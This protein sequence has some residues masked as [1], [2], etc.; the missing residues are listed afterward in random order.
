MEDCTMTIKHLVCTTLLTLSLAMT[1]YGAVN[2]TQT[3]TAASEDQSG[4][5]IELT[6]SKVI[7]D[8]FSFKVPDDWKG[9]CMLIQDGDNLEVYDKTAYDEDGSGLLFTIAVYEDT[10]YRDLAGC[11]VLGFCGN[12]TYILEDQ[13]SADA[14]DYSDAEYKIYEK[15]VKAVKKSFV[16][17]VKEESE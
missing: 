9:A 14:E 17:L 4:D 2:T 16:A 3:I 6:G 11:T 15:A 12:R 7:T 8:D 13:Y 5:A 10:S 1:T